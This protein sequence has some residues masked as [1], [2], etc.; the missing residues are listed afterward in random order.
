MKRNIK[1]PKQ[2]PAPLIPDGA[3][4]W[5]GLVFAILT[6]LFTKNNYEPWFY[7]SLMTLVYAFCV[8]MVNILTDDYRMW[9][10]G[11]KKRN[12]TIQNL[13]KIEDLIPEIRN[14]K[15]EPLEIKL[16]ISFLKIAEKLQRSIDTSYEAI[17]ALDD[18]KSGVQYTGFS[19]L[20]SKT[21][22]LT[23]TV[24][25]CVDILNYPSK[26][27]NKLD[28]KIKAFVE[29]FEGFADWIPGLSARANS[30]DLFNATTNAI[31]LRSLRNLLKK[32]QE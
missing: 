27:G 11:I 10:R 13:E 8:Y 17:L 20:F 15:N 28:E 4:V 26:A 25:E 14:T 6:Y 16:G 1:A 7:I 31:L 32:E 22:Q 3:E 18:Q 23:P 9:A 29:G 30:G 19:D 2:R 24:V 12:T 21:N 5:I